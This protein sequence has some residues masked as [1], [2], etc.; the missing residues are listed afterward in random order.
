[1]TTFQ[2][3]ELMSQ[4]FSD[5]ENLRKARQSDLTNQ[6]NAMLTK[7]QKRLQKKSKEDG[8]DEEIEELLDDL[9]RSRSNLSNGIGCESDSPLDKVCCF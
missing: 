6:H 1:M 7:L 8:E 5:V 9:K 2:L 3:N 4:H